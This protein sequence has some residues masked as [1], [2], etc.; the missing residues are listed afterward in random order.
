M[1][2]P[3]VRAHLKQH[4]YKQ[5]AECATLAAGVKLIK[6]SGNNVSLNK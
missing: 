1:V 4:A 2:F 6:W 5:I 3:I